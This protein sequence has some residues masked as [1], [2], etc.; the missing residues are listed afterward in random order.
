MGAFVPQKEQ[1]KRAGEGVDDHHAKPPGTDDD[2]HM[3]PEAGVQAPGEPEQYLP[4]R[5]R[6]LSVDQDE[7]DHGREKGAQG[8]PGQDERAHRERGLQDVQTAWS[9]RTL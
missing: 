3:E 6:V 8:N 7:C 2:P 5:V 1:V 4:H 9:V